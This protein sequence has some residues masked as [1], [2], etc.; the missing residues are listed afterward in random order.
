M[1]C[2]YLISTI[3][4]CWG[5]PSDRHSSAAWP[6]LFIQRSIL[7]RGLFHIC[8][9]WPCVLLCNL[10]NN[11]LLHVN[12]Q[13]NNSWLVEHQSEHATE[14]WCR[15]Q[16]L[17]QTFIFLS[18]MLIHL[19]CLFFFISLQ[20]FCLSFGKSWVMKVQGGGFYKGKIAQ[21]SDCIG[22]HSEPILIYEKTLTP[23]F[24]QQR[25]RQDSIQNHSEAICVKSFKIF[26]YWQCDILGLNLFYRW[27]KSRFYTGL[28]VFY[29]ILFPDH[30][31]VKD[32]VAFRVT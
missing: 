17:T 16:W 27:W 4:N 1:Y 11:Y 20:V 28:I 8:L 3:F 30:S 31:N 25:Q 23:K 10:S 18:E 19:C 14:H 26:I 13:H 12:E 21:P 15:T 29:C 32:N 6:V 22:T 24:H 5:H 9:M 2:T 7:F